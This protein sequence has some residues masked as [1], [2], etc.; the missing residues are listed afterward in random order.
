M[1]IGY[2]SYPG[3]VWTLEYSPCYLGAIVLR[4]TTVRTKCWYHKYDKAHSRGLSLSYLAEHYSTL[5]HEGVLISMST[6]AH[7]HASD[8]M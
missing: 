4:A 5:H 8:A 7:I 2:F 3:E 6:L 1:E